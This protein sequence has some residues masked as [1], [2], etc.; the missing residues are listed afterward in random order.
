MG[1]RLLGQG[2][3]LGRRRGRCS[4]RAS[5]LSE[6]SVKISD[7]F[8]LRHVSILCEDSACQVPIR[9]AAARWFDN[10]HQK[11]VPRSRIPRST[12]HFSYIGTFGRAS[13]ASSAIVREK[14]SAPRRAACVPCSRSTPNLLSLLRFSLLG[15]VDSNFPGNSLWT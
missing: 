14:K 13:L 6:N 15:F 2:L 3:A 11:V 1:L 8:V 5:A 9:A 12:S 4:Y 10:P 7:L